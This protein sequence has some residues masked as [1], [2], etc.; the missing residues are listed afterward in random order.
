MLI[1]EKSF[2]TLE[3]TSKPLVHPWK[4]LLHHLQLLVHLLLNLV[5]LSENL[6]FQGLMLPRTHKTWWE[7]VHHHLMEFS[8]PRNIVHS[9]PY[10]FKINSF[11]INFNKVLYIFLTSI[12]DLMLSYFNT[13]ISI[14]MCV[15]VCVFVNIW[16]NMYI[17][18]KKTYIIYKI[19]INYFNTLFGPY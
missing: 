12:R 1:D 9:V 19:S 15:C 4:I 13:S 2:S 11:L 3:Q 18:Y 6:V 16:N 5:H 10:I 17:T 7:F 14:Y 8:N